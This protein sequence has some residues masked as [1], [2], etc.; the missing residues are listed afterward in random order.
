[1][2]NL[3]TSFL[4][5]AFALF[6]GSLFSIG[7]VFKPD[8]RSN[9]KASEC[10]FAVQDDVA[11]DS[12]SFGGSAM[13]T[14]GRVSTTPSGKAFVD[15][16]KIRDYCKE[17]NA[18]VAARNY[19]YQILLT[20]LFGAFVGVFA[21][22]ANPLMLLALALSRF[23][24]RF[25]SILIAVSAIALGL[26]SYALRAVPFNESSM[27]AGN[28]NVVDYLGLG[29]YLWMA[30]LVVFALYCFFSKVEFSAPS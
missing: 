5:V 15:K 22:F 6:V 18:P 7:I 2:R 12:F 24:K 11:C 30:S 20:G 21:W 1:V 10:A 27:D 25:A 3:R 14:C 16:Q 29:F 23:N 4:I 13:T 28:L 9:P 8:A 19:G 26:Q 17:W